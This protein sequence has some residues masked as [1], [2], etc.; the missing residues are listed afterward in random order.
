MRI[1]KSTERNFVVGATSNGGH[2]YAAHCALKIHKNGMCLRS[3]LMYASLFSVQHSRMPESTTSNHQTHMKTQPI[4]GSWSLVNTLC[5][6]CTNNTVGFGTTIILSR[7][8]RVANSRAYHTYLRSV[9]Q[10]VGNISPIH[11]M[12][13]VYKLQ[14]R[15]R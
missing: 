14:Q 15:S 7:T 4:V 6:D 1:N 12:T 8:M 5:G 2:H 9:D 11:K 10:Q 3:V 13:H